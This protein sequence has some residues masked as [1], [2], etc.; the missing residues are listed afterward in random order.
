[1]KFGDHYFGGIDTEV[2]GGTVVLFTS[3]SLNVDD[4]FLA[5][6]LCNFSIT[7]FEGYEQLVLCQLGWHPSS[8]EPLW[9][10][11]KDLVTCSFGLLVALAYP[12][13]GLV[14]LGHSEVLIWNVAFI[15]LSPHK[16]WFELIFYPLTFFFASAFFLNEWLVRS[17]Y[18]GS[19]LLRFGIRLYDNDINAEFVCSLLVALFSVTLTS[20]VL[21]WLEELRANSNDQIDEK[22][23]DKAR[24]KLKGVSS[25]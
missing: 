8:C 5:V 3:D 15:V 9:D 23:N 10:T 16:W 6:H 19:T 14:A 7:V 1:M 2:H 17:F 21:Y 4:I 18:F 11:A 12:E 24:R 20:K 25:N 22:G 13:N